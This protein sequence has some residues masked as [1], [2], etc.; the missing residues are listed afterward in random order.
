MP[1]DRP[2]LCSLIGIR[3][4]IRA[5]PFG[6]LVLS[7]GFATL[8]RLLDGI[9][10]ASRPLLPTSQWRTLARPGLTLDVIGSGSVVCDRP[11]NGGFSAKGILHMLISPRSSGFYPLPTCRDYQAS[12]ALS[13]QYY[14]WICHPLH[15]RRFGVSLSVRFYDALGNLRHQCRRASLG[16]THH[17]PISRPA[18]HRFDSPDT[19]PRLA[20]TARPSHQRHIAGSLFATYMGSASCFLQTPHFWR[21]PLPCWRGPSVR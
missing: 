13:H 20:T 4:R 2:E 5:S 17:L 7:S 3:R 10:I 11:S 12:S 1:I 8:I 6:L 9:A 19:R 16:K 15:P 21:P 14:S 18:S